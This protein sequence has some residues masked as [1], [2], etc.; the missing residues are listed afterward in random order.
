MILG[1]DGGIFVSYD[2]GATSDHRYNIPLGEVYAVG[3]DMEDP[4]NIY[5][6]L[7]DHENWKGPSNGPSGEITLMDWMAVGNDDGMFTL[8]DPADS[9]WLYTTR[10]YG[11][12]A[13][14]DQKLGTRTEHHAPAGRG[15]AA[16][17]LHLGDPLPH[18][19]P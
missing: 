7:Q 11:G 13:R 4:Y 16:L 5:A 6:G 14:I 17:P 9:R 2:G 12:Q 8:P 19:P 1:S 3:V 15:K 18:L 10:Q